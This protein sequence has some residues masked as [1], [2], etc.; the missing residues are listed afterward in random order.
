[1]IRDADWLARVKPRSE[2]LEK[3][4]NAVSTPNPTLRPLIICLPKIL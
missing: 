1:M 2:S 3:A 4:V